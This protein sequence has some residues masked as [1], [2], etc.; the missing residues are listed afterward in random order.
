MDL[1]WSTTV[2]A[3]PQFLIRF[4]EPLKGEVVGAT[5]TKIITGR[6]GASD[7]SQVRGLAR[8]AYRRH[9]AEIRKMVPQ[10]RILELQLGDW[11]SL[12]AFLGKDIPDVAFS[13]LNDADA[14]RQHIKQGLA[15]ELLDI[16]KILL[17]P[18]AILFLIVCLVG[19]LLNI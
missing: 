17:M 13:K 12:C 18:V 10:D 3:W 15:R 8:E 2:D 6:A 19:F 1:L 9:Y 5:T 4:I 11:K 14:F 16:A 7:P